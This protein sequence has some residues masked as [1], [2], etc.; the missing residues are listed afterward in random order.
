[1][2]LAYTYLLLAGSVFV[3]LSTYSYLFLAGRIWVDLHTLGQLLV[4]VGRVWAYSFTHG[5]LLV[6][7]MSGVDFSPAFTYLRVRWFR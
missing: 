3:D 4:L 5:Y 2:C 6:V 1:M 7:E